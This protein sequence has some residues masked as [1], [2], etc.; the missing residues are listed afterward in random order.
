[1]FTIP[2]LEFPLKTKTFSTYGTTNTQTNMIQLRVLIKSTLVFYQKR[3]QFKIMMF[4]ILDAWGQEWNVGPHG[5]YGIERK[6]CEVE[7]MSEDFLTTDR[8]L[9]STTGTIRK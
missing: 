5:G 1:M 7:I 4:F 3:Y 8:V 2:Q 9:D 6:E